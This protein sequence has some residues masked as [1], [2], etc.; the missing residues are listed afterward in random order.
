MPK[1][2]CRDCDRCT[3]TAMTGCLM[4][5]WR[6]FL[7]VCNVFTL[8]LLFSMKKKCP[9]CGHPLS[10]HHRRKDGSFQD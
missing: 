9:Q 7:G 2:G 4:W 10:A 5:P 3:E 8:G 1:G 6:F